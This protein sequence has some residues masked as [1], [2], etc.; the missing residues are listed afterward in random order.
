MNFIEDQTGVLFILRNIQTI[1]PMLYRKYL[2]ETFLSNMLMFR[3]G[4]SVSVVTPFF[5]VYFDSVAFSSC[6]RLLMSA[7]LL[8]KVNVLSG[9]L[10]LTRSYLL[11]FT[12]PLIQWNIQNFLKYHAPNFQINKL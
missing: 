2:K 6:S 12:Y 11:I 5:L 10:S 3:S 8:Y 9:F 7:K 4:K 1:H